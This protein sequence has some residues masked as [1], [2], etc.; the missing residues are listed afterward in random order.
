MIRIERI[1]IEIEPGILAFL[2]LFIK[3]AEDGFAWVASKILELSCAVFRCSGRFLSVGTGSCARTTASRSA[4][5][6]DGGW[7]CW[8]DT[9]VV[10]RMPPQYRM[11]SPAAVPSIAFESLFAKRGPF[12]N[13]FWT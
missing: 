7:D 3:T 10:G 1:A 4:F 5:C 13:A 2:R 8:A 6:C 11:T 9:R 12:G